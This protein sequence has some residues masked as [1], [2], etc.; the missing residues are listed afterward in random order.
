M[1]TV[2]CYGYCWDNGR[3]IVV[4]DQCQFGA[5]DEDGGP[6]NKPTRFTTNCKGIAE[7]L[8][9][10]CQ[11]LGGVFLRVEGGRQV[12]CNGKTARLAAIY[13]FDLCRAI[14]TGFKARMECAGRVS[15]T[16]VGF[17]S[18]MGSDMEDEVPSNMLETG[19]SYG[20]LLKLSVGNREVFL[21]YLTSQQLDH[22]LVREARAKEVEYVRSMGLW[23]KKP[24][25]ECWDKSG[26]PPVTVRW[27][28]TNK[29]DDKSPKIRS[30]LV[31]RQVRGPRQEVFQLK[32]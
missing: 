31:A 9:K 7:G 24:V 11:G 16:S 32:R 22:S 29:G 12:L 23:I 13:P 6:I 25:K 1:G 3:A 5:V 15:P 2:G 28:D 21:D 8:S 17:L 4:G 26:R 19:N 10:R 14:L 27:A 20:E 30:R 18:L